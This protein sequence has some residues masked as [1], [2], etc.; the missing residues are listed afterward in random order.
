MLWSLAALAPLAAIYLLKV[1]PRRRP[2]TA[3]FLWRQIVQEHR[4]HH[5][6]H[7]LRDLWSLLLMALAFAAVAFA[8]AEP[9]WGDA[10]RRDLLLVIDTSA[11]MAA[12]DGGSTRLA[13]AQERIRDVAR[14]MD[15]VQRVAVATIDRDLRFLSHLTDNPREILAV[16]DRVQASNHKLNL[17]AL[18]RDFESEQPE[19]KDSNAKRHRVLLVSDGGFDA[20]TLPPHIEFIRV[21]GQ[22][23]NIG[24]VAADLDFVPGE[25][26]QLRFFF[27][28]A[29]S[30]RQPREIDLLL[31]FISGGATELKKVIPISVGPGVNEP[32]VLT[33]EGAQPGRWI[34]KLDLNDSLEADNTVHLV[35]RQPPPIDIS[36]VAED[37]FFLEHSVLAFSE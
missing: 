21:G 18:P 16:V 13:R 33:I 3:L 36:V 6:L 20:A 32:Q 24:I 19:K 11:S 14:S 30:G 17:R 23:D 2:T 35:A 28:T 5:L 7:R 10:D 1:R 25:R 29:S 22:K 8:L 27:Q 12:P 31:S 26:D 15:G 4:P 9:R 34:A 37:R